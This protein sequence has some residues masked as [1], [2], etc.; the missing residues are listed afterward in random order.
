MKIKIPKS[1]IQE[2]GVKG[3]NTH[4][5]REVLLQ[6]ATRAMEKAANYDAIFRDPFVWETRFPAD[7]V[8]P[9]SAPAVLPPVRMAN[10]L[11]RRCL[12]D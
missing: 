2:K 9:S 7:V 11:R 4:T 3:Q 5:A 12:N 8:A 1:L 6:I 10:S